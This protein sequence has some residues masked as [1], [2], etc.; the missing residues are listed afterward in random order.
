MQVDADGDLIVPR[1][2]KGFIQIEHKKS[3]ELSL[4]GLQVWRGA[5][6]LAD[7]LFHNRK[8]FADKQILELGSGVG[9]TSIAAGIYA[10]R[11]IISTDINLGGLLDLIK[12]NV[13]V[14]KQMINNRVAVHVMELNF[15]D[16]NWSDELQMAVQNANLIIAADVIYDNDITDEFV[17]TLKQILDPDTYNRRRDK[18]VYI[19]L[20]KRYVFTLADLD[21]IAPCYEYFLQRFNEVQNIIHWRFDQVPIDFPQYFDYLRSKEFVL[22][23]LYIN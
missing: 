9:L 16:R 3:T 1:Q 14:N 23:K 21:T 19:A 20:E 22:M 7:F 5:L 17:E 18:E 11:N 4:V 15:K 13:E 12:S 2:Q 6:I 10:K 8:N